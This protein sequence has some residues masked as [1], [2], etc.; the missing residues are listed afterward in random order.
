MSEQTRSQ[1]N[2]LRP[3]YHELAGLGC[4]AIEVL[5]RP[6]ATLDEILARHDVNVEALPQ[7]LYEGIVNMEDNHPERSVPIIDTIYTLRELADRGDQRLSG[8]SAV[9]ASHDAFFKAILPTATIEQRRLFRH[10]MTFFI[11]RLLHPQRLCIT[12]DN[13]L[14][15]DKSEAVDKVQI[16]DSAGTWR[17]V[18]HEGHTVRQ[19]ADVTVINEMFACMEESNAPW[20]KSYHMTTSAAVP[21]IV[22]QGALLSAAELGRR[23]EVIKTGA[24]LAELSDDPD[25]RLSAV[26]SF[27]F[28]SLEQHYGTLEW[29]DDC[30]VCFQVD[31]RRLEEFRKGQGLPLIGWQYGLDAE[32]GS[33]KKLGSV[34]PLSCITGAY[35]WQRYLPGFT[36]A[37][38]AVAPDIPV[39]SLE[40]MYLCDRNGDFLRRTLGQRR[41]QRARSKSRGGHWPDESRWL[42]S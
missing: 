5:P 26:Y 42:K 13:G 8:W 33:A 35:C 27:P 34:V 38:Q 18:P 16:Y 21:G 4:R 3:E 9:L 12:F 22:R 29:F 23:S 2:A 15:R 17:T 32:T 31:E 1:G 36:D 41:A 6:L 11:Q 24:W 19:M 20:D 10:G 40:A 28:V 14:I 39:H 7:A 37:I 30:A 25:V